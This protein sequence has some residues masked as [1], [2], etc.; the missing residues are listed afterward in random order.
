M[1]ACINIPVAIVNKFFGTTIGKQ[2]TFRDNRT[3]KLKSGRIFYAVVF[4][5]AI[6]HSESFLET[7]SK[8]NCVDMSVP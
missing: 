1:Y 4:T 8:L 7:F 3:H 6:V 2:Q 5:L